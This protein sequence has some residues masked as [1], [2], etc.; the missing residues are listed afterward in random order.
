MHY[1]KNL[2]H[3]LTPDRSSSDPMLAATSHFPGHN[4]LYFSSHVASESIPDHMGPLFNIKSKASV[5]KVDSEFFKKIGYV[6]SR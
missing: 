2:I 5:V 4:Y 1:E 3:I 6:F